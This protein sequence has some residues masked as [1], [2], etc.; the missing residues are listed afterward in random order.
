MNKKYTIISTEAE[1]ALNKVQHLFMIKKKKQPLSK[2]G[3]E[4]P[5]INT[6]EAISGK[7]TA[8]I[9]LNGE[10]LKA[11]PLRSGIRQGCLLS[12]LLF[13][14]VLDILAITIKQEKEIKGVQVRKEHNFH[15]F[16]V[17]WYY[18]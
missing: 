1:A 12:P 16:Q 13:N 10:E 2:T 14:T 9:A 15:Y 5:H 8:D 18:T 6:T 4:R 3:T 17:T 7:P 11:R